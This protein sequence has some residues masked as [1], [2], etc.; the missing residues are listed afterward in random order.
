MFCRAVKGSDGR[1][2]VD[3]QFTQK[4]YRS[5]C[6]K[7]ILGRIRLRMREKVLNAIKDLLDA[8]EDGC[9]S[10]PE[11]QVSFNKW[12]SKWRSTASSCLL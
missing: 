3:D 2:E 10:H 8:G 4:S 9:I 5:I 7:R 1:L 11:T 6:A 12:N